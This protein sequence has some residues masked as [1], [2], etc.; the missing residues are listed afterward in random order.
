V[1]CILDVCFLYSP[2]R[3]VADHFQD[4]KLGMQGASTLADVLKVNK[5][6]QYLYCENN[7]IALTGHTDLI[8]AL[9]RNTTLLYLPPTQPDSSPHP[10]PNCRLIESY[11]LENAL[12]GLIPFFF[13]FPD[14]CSRR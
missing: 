8:N 5:T 4:Q 12:I 6:L 3:I 2:L 7:G 11:L 10:F 9:H 13:S 14:L 1:R